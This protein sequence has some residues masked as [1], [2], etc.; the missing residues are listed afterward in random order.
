[1]TNTIK[2]DVGYLKLLQLV[3]LEDP[4]CNIVKF[5]VLEVHK[6]NL[7]CVGPH[8]GSTTRGPLVGEEKKQTANPII[9]TLNPNKDLESSLLVT[10]VPTWINHMG[11]TWINDMGPTSW[12]R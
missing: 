7:V 9:L 11:P 2:F 1:M 4:T 6:D 3:T 5:D 10:W 8:L 12:Q